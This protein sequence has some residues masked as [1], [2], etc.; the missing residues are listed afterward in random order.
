MLSASVDAEIEQQFLVLR[1]I[2]T[3]PELDPLDRAAFHERAKRM[4]AALPQ[5]LS[6]ALI[7][8][9]MVEVLLNTAQSLDEAPPK[10][11][12]P[13]AIRRVAA[14]RTLLVLSRGGQ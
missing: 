12:I 14:T 8:A 6:I 5:W 1:A 9:D 13:E 11:V 4:A 7:D 2:A 10:A 3:L